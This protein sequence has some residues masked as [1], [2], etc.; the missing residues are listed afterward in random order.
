MH[1]LVVVAPAYHGRVTASFTRAR[2]PRRRRRRTVLRVFLALLALAVVVVIALAAGVVWW[3]GAT[4]AGDPSELARLELQ[5]LAGS[6]VSATASGPAGAKIPV[7]VVHGRLVPK[8]VVD[9]G[10][11]VRV[12][13]VVRR[14][15]W[16]GWAIGRTRHE[17]LTVRTPVAHVTN[18]WLTVRHGAPLRVRFAAGVDRVAYRGRKLRRR[19]PE[20]GRRSARSGPRAR[21]YS[22]LRPGRGSDWVLRF[23]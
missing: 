9:P 13:V 1:G 7:A 11:R 8:A 19:R 20:R 10:V 22:R 17:Q 15:G 4:L 6:L 14:P 5:P 16:L 21:S 2:P 18:R 3:S 12:E 23:A